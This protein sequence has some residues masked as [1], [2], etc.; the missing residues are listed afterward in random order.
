[1][2]S[3][4]PDL[5]VAMIVKNESRCLARCLESVRSLDAELVV[6]D[7]GSTDGTVAIARDHG[8]V[9]GAFTWINDFS[10]A[11]NYSIDSTKGRWILVLDADEYAS[12]E[13]VDE[14]RQFIHGP[15]AVGRLRIVSEFRRN[16]QSLTSQGFV[17]RLFPRGARFEGRIHEQLVS[18]L[19]RRSLGAPLWHDG[20]LETNKSA[21]N[22]ELLQ[23][24]LERA[25]DNAHFLFQLALE[26][27]SLGQTAKAFDCLARA[28]ALLKPE[29]AFAP[30]VV[31]D[32]LH[33]ITELRQFD[34]GL[35]LIERHGASLEDFPDFHFA[36]GIFY[37]E[38]VRSNPS[39]NIA[40][41][42]RI[43]QAYKRCLELGETDRYKSV[44]GTGSFLAWYNLGT[45]YHVFGEDAIAR[46]C[47]EKAA[48]LG[49][50]PAAEFL[51][52]LPG[53]S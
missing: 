39:G 32:Y 24:E 38:L 16:G 40:F 48:A 51:K 50:S 49:H 42:P 43:E 17:S 47:F 23:R 12:P 31:V 41:L 1:M 14:I 37:M 52:K 27:T 20:Y 15:P 4:T 45:L 30:N 29:D 19:P 33:A 7:T 22:I 34:T 46:T 25:P 35:K 44:R 8:A 13:L 53:K 28:L 18:P 6:I 3:P 26:H 36:C 2:T 21:R 5:S 9:T 11:R 10:A